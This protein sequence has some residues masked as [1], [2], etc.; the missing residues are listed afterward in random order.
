MIDSPHYC[1][2]MADN[3]KVDKDGTKAQHA[4]QL[5]GWDAR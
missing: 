5:L 1:R 3:D 4:Q 2:T